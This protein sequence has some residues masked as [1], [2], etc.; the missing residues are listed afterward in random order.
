[1]F[2]SIQLV[3]IQLFYAFVLFPKVSAPGRRVARTPPEHFVA[4]PAA[5]HA[6]HAAAL[7]TRTA[8][9]TSRAAREGHVVDEWD[10]DGECAAA[11]LESEPAGGQRAARRCSPRSPRSRRSPS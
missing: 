5:P 10:G 11:R 6:A 3:S 4:P 8:R 1:M 7:C 2:Q 9:R